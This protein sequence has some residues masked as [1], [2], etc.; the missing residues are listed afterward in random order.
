MKR[1]SNDKKNHSLEFNEFL[2][3]EAVESK[4]NRDIT[5]KELYNS[6][7]YGMAWFMVYMYIGSPV[8]SGPLTRIRQA[9]SQW[10]SWRPSSSRLGSVLSRGRM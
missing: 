9:A 7:R 2:K 4:N 3:M 1:F 5:R 6:F 8:L 10:S